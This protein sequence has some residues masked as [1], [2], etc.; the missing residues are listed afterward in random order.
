MHGDPATLIVGKLNL[1]SVQTGSDLDAKPVR[2]FA[3]AMGATNRPSWPIECREESV[4]GG[5]CFVPPKPGTHQL[6]VLVQKQFPLAVAEARRQ[7]GGTNYIGEHHGC[8]HAIG[9]D[10]SSD[11]IQESLNLGDNPCPTHTRWS[12][13]GNSTNRA[14]TIRLAIQRPSSTLTSLSPAR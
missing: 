14:P 1:S 7:L 12:S 11:P 13:P 2:T 8:P 6:V 3:D 4:T 5:S 9:L 10:W